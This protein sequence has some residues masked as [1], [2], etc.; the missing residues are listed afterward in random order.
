MIKASRVRASVKLNS[1]ALL[2][3]NKLW[4]V[5]RKKIFNFVLLSY[6]FIFAKQNIKI[7]NRITHQM[8]NLIY[9]LHDFPFLILSFL[10]LFKK[11][12]QFGDSINLIVKDILRD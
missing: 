4:R 10:S 9:I 7:F 3:Y 1:M 12:N 11:F 6:T 8:N 2:C 5:K